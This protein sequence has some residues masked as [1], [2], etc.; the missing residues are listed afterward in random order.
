MKA[1]A[2]D[3]PGVGGGV[4]ILGHTT[5]QHPLCVDPLQP[6]RDLMGHRVAFRPTPTEFHH[7]IPLRRDPPVRVVC[8]R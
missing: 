1:C 8:G 6:R 4:Q 5:F 3:E 7:T 2:Q